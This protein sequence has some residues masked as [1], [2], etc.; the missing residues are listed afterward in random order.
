MWSLNKNTDIY[1]KAMYGSRAFILKNTNSSFP[2]L[3][4]YTVLII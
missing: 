2:F 1:G 3:S 4:Y